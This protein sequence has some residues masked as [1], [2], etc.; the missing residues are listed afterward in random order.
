MF[1]KYSIAII[2]G[3]AKQGISHELLYKEVR[4]TKLNWLHI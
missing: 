3:G 4:P 1:R 2:I